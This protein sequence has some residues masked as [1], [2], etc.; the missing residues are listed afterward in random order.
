MG[1]EN[2]QELSYDGTPQYPLLVYCHDPLDDQTTLQ[3]VKGQALFFP[4]I[5]FQRW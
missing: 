5:P 2:G 1:K 3:K 4:V